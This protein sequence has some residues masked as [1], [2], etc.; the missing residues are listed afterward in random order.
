MDAPEHWGG[1]PPARV[2]APDGTLEGVPDPSLGPDDL[3]A[4]LRWMV[5][6]RRLDRGLAARA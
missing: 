3:R 5:L 4:M 1:T 2:L 6:A